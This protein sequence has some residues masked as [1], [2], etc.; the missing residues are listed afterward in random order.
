[1]ELP[2]NGSIYQRNYIMQI[3]KRFSL[4]NA[5]PYNSSIGL[6]YKIKYMPENVNEEKYISW[7]RRITYICGH[8]KSSEYH[9]LLVGI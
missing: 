5:K 9:V 4:E 8:S 1:M 3:V 6:T 7:S 2:V